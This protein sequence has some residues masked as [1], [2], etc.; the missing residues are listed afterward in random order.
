MRY[1]LLRMTQLILSSMDSE[2]V[3]SIGDTTEASQVVDIIETTFNDIV[4]NTDFPGHWDLFELEASGD[5]TRPTLMYLPD[6][7]QNI[8][9]VEYD[10]RETGSTVRLMRPV[11]PLP[12]YE[13]FDRMEGLDSADASNYQ[14][15]YL[16]GAETFDVRGKND[17]FPQYFTT[18]DNRTLLFDS[19]HSDYDTTLVGNKTACYGKKIPTFTRQNSFVPDL[20]PQHFSYLFNEA[21]AACHAQLKQV[22]NG[23]AMKGARTAKIAIQRNRYNT[24]KPTYRTRTDLPNYGRK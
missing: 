17:R 3:N 2:E 18:V 22:E 6:G 21:K 9:W 4:S 24:A 1:T 20:D 13:F 8:E 16:V 19:Y 11:S 12:K 14:F 15:N 5:N 23:V 7:V 10:N